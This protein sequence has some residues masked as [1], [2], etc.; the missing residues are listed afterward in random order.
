MKDY[1]AV[2]PVYG[3]WD[4]LTAFRPQFDLMFDA[5][6]NH[7]CAQGDWFRRFLRDEPAYRDFFVTVAFEDLLGG[8]I[9]PAGANCSLEFTRSPYQSRWLAVADSVAQPVTNC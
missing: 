7:L 5:V 4:D 9:L 6:F 3:T 2:A 1:F 8:G